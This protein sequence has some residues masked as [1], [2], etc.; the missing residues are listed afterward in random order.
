VCAASNE[1]EAD[2]ANAAYVRSAPT[3]LQGSRRTREVIG[4]LGAVAPPVIGEA[5]PHEYSD[6]EL[7]I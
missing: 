1:D 2:P 7:R 6:I 3:F 4:D 5:D